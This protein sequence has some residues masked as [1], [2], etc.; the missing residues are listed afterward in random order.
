MGATPD[1]ALIIND[2]HLG[3]EDR[4]ALATTIRVGIELQPDLVVINGDF[5]DCTELHKNQLGKR[6]VA[7]PHRSPLTMESEI[8]L[9]K[10]VLQAIRAGMPNSKIIYN[11][12]N[13]EQR[14]GKVIRGNLPHLSELCPSLPSL[15]G[16]DD[17]KI[18][19]VPAGRAYQVGKDWTVTHGTR[20]SANAGKLAMQEWGGS[21]V[22]G[23]SHR[24]KLYSQTYGDG[25]TVYG[26]EGGHLHTPQ[27]SYTPREI[28]D[29][30]Q[31]FVLLTRAGQ[32]YVPHLIPIIGGKAILPGKT[33]SVS[34]SACA[35]F[36]K[37]LG[38]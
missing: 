9:G 4:Q 8:T 22:Q 24:L 13:H 12:G 36:W 2:V 10:R 16:L 28:P 17:L 30:Q 26:I 33:T 23:H 6:A 5:L 25:R 19:W 21:V 29:W 15:L 34:A 27:A 31:G 32:Q 35:S 1:L 38:R 3:E 11:E 18:E 20:C 7:T 14:W 37:G